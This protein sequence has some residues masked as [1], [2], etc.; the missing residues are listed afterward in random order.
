MPLECIARQLTHFSLLQIHTRQI[1]MTVIQYMSVRASISSRQ[2][3]L[4]LRIP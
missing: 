4:S 2:A 3:P 1:G